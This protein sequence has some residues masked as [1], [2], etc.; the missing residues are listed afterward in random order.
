LGGGPN[1][2]SQGSFFLGRGG[3]RRGALSWVAAKNGRK[4]AAQIL[5]RGRRRR[6]SGRKRERPCFIKDGR[7]REA[8]TSPMAKKPGRKMKGINASSQNTKKNSCESESTTKKSK[9]Q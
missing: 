8:L 9:G 6:G 4:V 7:G 1:H 3:E 5:G 2:K